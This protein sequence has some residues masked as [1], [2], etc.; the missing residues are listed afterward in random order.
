MYFFRL[1]NVTTID[2]NGKET[3]PKFDQRHQSPFCFNVN[4]ISIDSKI[5]III[6]EPYTVY[7]IHVN[8]SVKWNIK[9]SIPNT[10]NDIII[11]GSPQKFAGQHC[12]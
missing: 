8:Q 2:F 7:Q 4:P 9:F 3:N 5:I 12:C 10:I 1:D 11:I 6:T